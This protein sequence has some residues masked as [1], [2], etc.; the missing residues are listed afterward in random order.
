L[1]SHPAGCARKR[2]RV[3]WNG[4]AEWKTIL[5]PKDVSITPVHL[6]ADVPFVHG[7]GYW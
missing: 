7:K 6:L 4:G 3:P 1:C 5:G 2:V